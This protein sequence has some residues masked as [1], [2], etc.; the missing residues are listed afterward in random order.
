[1]ERIQSSQ[2]WLKAM[3]LQICTNLL[4]PVFLIMTGMAILIFMS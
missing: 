3:G 1:M 4:R 2:K